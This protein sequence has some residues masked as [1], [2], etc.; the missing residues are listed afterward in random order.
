MVTLARRVRVK[1]MFACFG[2]NVHAMKI[3]MG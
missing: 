2:Y 3:M 1:F